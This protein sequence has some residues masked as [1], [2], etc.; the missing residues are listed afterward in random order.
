MIKF[1]KEGK[2]EKYENEK[3]IAIDSDNSASINTEIGMNYIVIQATARN[4]ITKLTKIYEVY[5]FNTTNKIRFELTDGKKTKTIEPTQ[6]QMIEDLSLTA[7]ITFKGFA[8][9]NAKFV[10]QAFSDYQAKEPFKVQRNSPTEFSIP[11]I[12]KIILLGVIMPDNA[13][14]YYA[15]FFK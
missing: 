6:Y 8:G 10:I 11:Q 1:N 15:I 14:L 3:I 7:P 5:K 4:G 9:D 13:Q 12:P 2:I